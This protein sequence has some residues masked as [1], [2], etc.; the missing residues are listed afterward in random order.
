[1]ENIYK[2]EDWCGMNMLTV[3]EK[4]KISNQINVKLGKASTDA[5]VM[6]VVGH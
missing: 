4:A 3:E 2:E 6:V 1:M 5:I